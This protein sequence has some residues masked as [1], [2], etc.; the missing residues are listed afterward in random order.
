MKIDGTAAAEC[1]H[2]MR[3]IRCPDCE[4]TFSPEAK[5]CPHCGRPF[6]VTYWTPAR[7]ILAIILGLFVFW[8][9]SNLGRIFG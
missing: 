8:F 5:A 7:I 6:N 4:K 3:L 1:T 2:Q 9:F